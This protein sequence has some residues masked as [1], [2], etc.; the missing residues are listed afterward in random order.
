MDLAIDDPK[1]LDASWISPLGE[2]MNACSSTSVRSLS[3]TVPL[4]TIWP[5][6]LM[7]CA[8]LWLPVP[9]KPSA[10]HEPAEY[11]T[12]RMPT[13]GPPSVAG[14]LVPTTWLDALMEDTLTIASPAG[15][16]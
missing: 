2:E 5:V 8:W 1:P 12:A 15:A 13:V 6:S 10:V 9:R 14:E 3:S 7:A 11:K 4:P 16:P